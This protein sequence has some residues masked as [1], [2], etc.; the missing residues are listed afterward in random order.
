MDCLSGKGPWQTY[1]IVYNDDKDTGKVFLW[2]NIQRVCNVDK[3]LG[4]IGGQMK[5][6]FTLTELLV[7][8]IVLGVLAS[9]AVPKF[10]RVLETRRTT[11]AENMLTSIR[12]EQEKRCAL[13]QKYTVSFSRIPTASYARISDSQAKTANY[14]YTLSATGA[15]ASRNTNSGNY[16]LK[17][18]SYKTGVI[19]CEGSGCEALNKN[20]ALCGDV[21]IPAT[22]ECAADD[23]A[24]P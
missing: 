9:V 18:P 23:T 17:I 2:Y 24:N 5:K 7:V 3:P 6:G 22:D 11:E 4:Y 19:C 15:A 21:M 16:V 14:I 20:Y 10:S 13:G 12:S 8:V 1:N